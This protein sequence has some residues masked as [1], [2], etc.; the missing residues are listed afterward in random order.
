M[1]TTDLIDKYRNSGA[2][3]T[4]DWDSVKQMYTWLNQ[5][6]PSSQYEARRLFAEGS[7]ALNKKDYNASKSLLAQSISKDS[8]WAPSL[9]RMGRA[10]YRLRQFEDAKSWYKKAIEAERGWIWP[11]LNLGQLCVETKDFAN[12]VDPLKNAIGLNS[13]KLSG[14]YFLGEAYTGLAM[15]CEA[16]VCYQRAIELA[17]SGADPSAVS[18]FSFDRTA[19]KRDSSLSASCP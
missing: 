5:L 9:N 15:Y 8:S 16:K 1:T 13:N 3:D 6:Q 4:T 2:D 10:C 17:Q 18:W 14:H 11:H 12:A 19:K 7:I